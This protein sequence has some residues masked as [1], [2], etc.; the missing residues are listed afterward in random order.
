ML[1]RFLS[2]LSTNSF[3]TTSNLYSTMAPPTPTLATEPDP[4][5]FSPPPP[6]HVP[7]YADVVAVRILLTKRLCLPPE[8][9][10]MILS[11]GSYAP[12]VRASLT[13]AM[14][15]SA[16]AGRGIP[17]VG[18]RAILVTPPIPATGF[19]RTVSVRFWLCS[20]DQGHSGETLQGTHRNSWTWFEAGI[21]R[22]EGAEVWE[23]KTAE[24]R[25]VDVTNAET[26]WPEE[27]LLKR[28]GRDDRVW[29]LQRN[30]NS[31]TNEEE[32][33]IEWPWKQ[34]ELQAV[35]EA[36]EDF[37]GEWSRESG[38]GVGEGFIQALKPGDRIVLFARAMYPGWANRVQ[39]AQC[40]IEYD[41]D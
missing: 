36:E 22:G 38:S 39:G 23:E 15:V 3:S 11:Y 21:M 40:E 32:H 25:G 17:N 12:R 35:Q 20:C 41:V 33:V 37:D 16:S 29:M 27:M 2:S 5:F 31:S 24:A 34:E 9:A 6:A 1:R 28:E 18:N 4:A 7:S 30:I 13:Y 26:Q 14:S 10:L 19:K 8:L